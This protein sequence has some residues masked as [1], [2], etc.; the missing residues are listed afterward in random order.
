MLA[1]IESVFI[2]CIVLVGGLACIYSMIKENSRRL[3]SIERLL[4][5]PTAGTA[6]APG[7]TQQTDADLLEHV[8]NGDINKA[9]GM[10]RSREN[11]SLREAEL[12]I[13]RIKVGMQ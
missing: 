3:K 12:A 8:K 11:V 5:S 1:T 2:L 13:N 9:I 10:Y 7:A 6:Q 4:M